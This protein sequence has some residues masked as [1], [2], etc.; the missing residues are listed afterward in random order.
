MGKPKVYVTRRIPAEGLA[1]L[2]EVSQVRVW[3][4]DCPVPRPILLAEA[5]DADALLTLLTERVDDEL[6]EAAPR[7]KIVS[8]YAVGYDNIDVPAATRRNIYV[9]NT[10]GVLTDATADLTFALL[11][12]AARRVAE[13]DRYLRAV[14]W[15]AWSPLLLLGQDRH[16]P[17]LVNKELAP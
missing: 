9:T 15:Q 16:P 8:N 13:G 10:P 3:E 4:G 12:A 7:L 14:R 2:Q 5:T 1:I 17:H 11:L 6:L